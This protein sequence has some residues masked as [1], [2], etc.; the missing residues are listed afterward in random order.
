[1][2]TAKVLVLLKNQRRARSVAAALA[3]TFTVQIAP[4]QKAS[5]AIQEFAPE[6][7]IIDLGPD[8]FTCMEAVRGSGSSAQFVLLKTRRT[9]SSDMSRALREA[10]LYIDDDDDPLVLR[11]AVARALATRDAHIAS[12]L[13]SRRMARELIQAQRVQRAILPAGHDLVEGVTLCHQYRAASELSG[14]FV[15]YAPA[16]CGRVAV[17]IAD[18]VGHG[19]AAAMLTI[20]IKSA[21]RSASA[22]DFEPSRLIGEISSVLNPL[23]HVSFA[24][25]IVARICAAERE[26]QY[27]NAGHP[28][29]L[30]FQNGKVL[31]KLE[32]TGTVLSSGVQ[33]SW[34]IETRPL[35]RNCGILMYTDG[36]LEAG[37][38]T[39]L[40]GEGRLLDA[41]ASHRGGGLPLIDS[42]MRPLLAQHH[43]QTPSDDVTLL[44]ATLGL[45]GLQ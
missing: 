24:T 30:L 15:D 2:E 4:V 17:I 36:V 6:C 3:N 14:D 29:G 19:I 22:Y 43:R 11:A 12:A 40:F 1:M 28:A 34:Q 9:S 44:C 10:T 32:P 27:V 21:F 23:G 45:P 41:I 31:T 37:T 5:L 42:I 26:I 8:A 7:L 20:L 25:A 33:G 16:G 13:K 39:G 38:D 35:P 18:A